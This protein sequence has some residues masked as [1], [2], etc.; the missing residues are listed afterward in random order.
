MRATPRGFTPALC[1]VL[2]TA[3]G[4]RTAYYAVWEKLGR[5]KRH[6]LRAQVEKAQTEQEKASEE[7]KDVLT[8]VKELYGFKGGDLERFY[9]KLRDD[10]EA[11]KDRAE[12]I[13]GRIKQVEQ[14]AADLFKEWESEINEMT[15]E[16][17]KTKSRQ[18]LRD[19]RK[20]YERLSVAMTKA[21]ASMEPVIRR[22]KDYVL[23]LKHNLNAQ[24][25]G[26]LKREVGEIETEVE[27]LI[28]DM[29][30]SINEANTFLKSFE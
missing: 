12:S 26:S 5:E 27:G 24:A 14:I 25:V 7:F 30:K 22:L 17:F 2:V 4:C 10:Y 15:N 6:L 8:R 13:E 9:N 28:R 20:R 29:K 3:I 19:T 18:S 16:K 23:Y 1:L 11:C 21:K